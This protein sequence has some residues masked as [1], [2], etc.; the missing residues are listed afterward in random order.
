[1]CAA[2]V[3]PTEDHPTP[4]WAAEEDITT[5][6]YREAIGPVSAAY[7]LPIFTRFEAA[8]R[9]GPSWNWAACLFTFN[10]LAYRKLWGAALAYAGALA[11]VAIGV[12]GIGRL[13]F[14]FSSE[15]E[16]MLLAIFAILAFV[17]PGLFGNVLFHANCKKRMNQA[18]QANPTLADAY[19]ALQRQASTL[20]RLAAF[21]VANGIACGVAVAGYVVLPDASTSAI[22]LQTIDEIAKS[23]AEAMAE[24]SAAPTTAPAVAPIAAPAPV[25]E[26]ITVAQASPAASIPNAASATPVNV[27]TPTPSAPPAAKAAEPATAPAPCKDCQREVVVS[28]PRIEPNVVPPEPEAKPKVWST[29]REP[30]VEAPPPRPVQ[31]TAVAASTSATPTTPA[32][33]PAAKSPSP[34]SKKAAVHTKEKAASKPKTVAKADPK[35]A[36]KEHPI[37]INVG[38]FAKEENAQQVR[39]KLISA[40]LPIDR[41]EMKSAKG[42][43]RVRVGPYS[44][45]E[46]AK[47][48]AEKVRSLKLDAS[49]VQL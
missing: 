36:D 46:E 13:V 45:M 10:W 2:N 17:I 33:T 5:R 12:F 28:P 4:S 32:V 47:A 37:Y 6:L 15:T 42:L 49:I 31:P 11:A 8:N 14:Q 27:E 19:T 48:A 20:K 43:H 23:R 40:G 1:M 25:V 38:L 9:A 34:S 30:Q 24:N 35:V 29:A 16:L 41:H 7:Y 18:L 26:A 21:M 39:D 22:K 44:S 3:T